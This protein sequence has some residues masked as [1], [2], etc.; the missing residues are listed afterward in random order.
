MSSLHQPRISMGSRLVALVGFYLDGRIQEPVPVD[1]ISF[2][3]N[4]TNRPPMQTYLGKIDTESIHIQS[5]KEACE[6]LAKSRQ[7]LVHE[8]KV[9][10]IRFKVSHGI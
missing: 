4:I 2:R 8:L 5:I 7:T 9:H 1:H 6:R 10:H 3:R